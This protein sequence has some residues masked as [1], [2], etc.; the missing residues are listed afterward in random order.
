L[1]RHCLVA[2]AKV[3]GRSRRAAHSLLEPQSCF[4]TVLVKRIWAIE[5][6]SILDTFH[7]LNTVETP[8]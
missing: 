5:I 6:L 7:R 2:R 1:Q 4:G 3:T 8:M